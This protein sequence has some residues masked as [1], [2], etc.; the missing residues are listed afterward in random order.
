MFLVLGFWCVRFL[1][2]FCFL[3]L[4]LFTLFLGFGLSSL[5]A[6]CCFGFRERSKTAKTQ[7]TV[8]GLKP[9]YLLFVFIITVIVLLLLFT[10][11]PAGKATGSVK[12]Q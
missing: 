2:F 10:I 11:Q 1:C 6:V 7:G 5:I 12:T 3:G 8:F 4:G 9:D